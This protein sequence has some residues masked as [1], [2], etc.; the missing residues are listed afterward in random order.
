MWQ[1]FALCTELICFKLD[2]RMIPLQDQ[3]SY[4]DSMGFRPKLSVV[5][6]DPLLVFWLRHAHERKHL[7][8]NYYSRSKK[9]KL[10]FCKLFPWDKARRRDTKDY[11][12]TRQTASI[13]IGPTN[14]QVTSARPQFRPFS[15]KTYYSLEPCLYSIALRATAL[16][17]DEYVGLND[18]TF[19]SATFFIGS[20]VTIR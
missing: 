18:L 5:V 7:I 16:Q 2:S 1:H 14:T 20:D 4:W 12:P 19:I 15:S 13:G 10:D 9:P 3:A 11:T 6:C 8:R 17:R